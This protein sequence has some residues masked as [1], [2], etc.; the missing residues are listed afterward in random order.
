VVD[1]SEECDSS[2][3]CVDCVC[4]LGAVSNGTYCVVP[5]DPNV[6]Q[7][8]AVANEAI[9]GGVV[10]G[11]GGAMVAT[12]V[13]LIVLAKKGKLNRKKKGD[14]E[15]LNKGGDNESVYSPIE[16]IGT[17]TAGSVVEMRKYYL[18]NMSYVCS[19]YVHRRSFPRGPH[20]HTV[21]TARVQTRNWSRRIRQSV[22][23]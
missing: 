21:L 5:V 17:P 2:E 11:V 20:E 15:R 16:T 19:L 12:A 7:P 1:S 10:G 9:I 3:Y 23:W 4:T 13:V 8:G 6:D 22:C 18:I 14:E